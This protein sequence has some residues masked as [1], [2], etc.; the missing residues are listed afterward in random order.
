M[1]CL[2]PHALSRAN[3]IHYAGQC[4]REW[5]RACVVR[6][7]CT[8]RRNFRYCI[9][10]GNIRRTKM[11][12]PEAA[13]EHI[14][15]SD[16]QNPAMTMTVNPRTT[17]LSENPWP[18]ESEVKVACCLMSQPGKRTDAVQLGSVTTKGKA[19]QSPQHT[20]DESNGNSL[21]A[22][23]HWY[24]RQGIGTECPCK[25][26][27]SRFHAGKVCLS[28]LSLSAGKYTSK[29]HLLQNLDRSY[30][31]RSP[32]GISLFPRSALRQHRSRAPARI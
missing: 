1:R 22:L 3:I 30:T 20:S 10:P 7:R 29:H 4:S 14:A 15:E 2:H 28:S 12:V 19:K 25:A 21:D 26:R 8:V 13:K 18:V 16:H 17:R 24:M 31:K 23:N 32:S 9:R 27:A 5:I 6:A 11:T